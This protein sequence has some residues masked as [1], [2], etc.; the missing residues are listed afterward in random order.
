MVITKPHY[1]F[2]K[3]NSNQNCI[4]LAVML[5][6]T[7]PVDL[8]TTENIYRT[9]FQ[10]KVKVKNISHTQQQQCLVLRNLHESMISRAQCGK[11][12]EHCVGKKHC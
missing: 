4:C 2:E 10:V 9:G 3:F 7:T 6:F 11:K 5:R 8:Q 1:I 12:R